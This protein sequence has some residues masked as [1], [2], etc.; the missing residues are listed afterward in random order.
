MASP[1]IVL[2]FPAQPEFVRLVR[3]TAADVASRAGLDFE[4]MDDLRI[5]V[6]E[7]CSLAVGNDGVLTLDFTFDDGAVTVEGQGPIGEFDEHGL[8]RR[9]IA[10]VADEHEIDTLEDAMRFRVVKRHRS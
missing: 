9:I 10:A 2:T 7:M 1:R 5:A 4:E 6:S 8:A 3:L